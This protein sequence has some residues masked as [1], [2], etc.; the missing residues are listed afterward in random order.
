MT[1]GEQIVKLR[2]RENIKRED[3]AKSLG[4]SYWALSK[5]ETNARTPDPE[6]MGVIA[7]Y[8]GVS[9]DYLHG[10][11]EVDGILNIWRQ[12]IRNGEK[13]ILKDI[14]LTEKHIDNMENAL[15]EKDDQ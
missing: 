14:V 7:D 1:I 11:S 6:T 8:F 4:I 15:N 10:R 12:R 13:I 5:Y 2:E 9:V 3:L